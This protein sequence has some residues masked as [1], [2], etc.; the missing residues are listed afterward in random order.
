[1]K[2][3]AFYAEIRKSLFN[4]S[5]S[6]EQVTGIEGILNAFEDYG[7]DRDKTLAYALA[8][9]H[10]ETGRKMVPVREG[11]ARSDASARR[12]VARRKYGKPGAYG[13]VFYGRGHVQ[14]TW[15]SNY[16]HTGKKIGID[17]V[18]DPDRVLDPELSARVLIEGLLDGRWN[19]SEGEGI[20]HYLPTNGKDD[21]RGARR[22]VNI[23]DKW[24]L[25][26]SYYLKYLSAIQKA[27][28]VP[29]LNDEATDE[30][31]ADVEGIDAAAQP[32]AASGYPPRTWID[33][34]IDAI[35]ALFKG[36]KK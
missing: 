12:I 34:L 32:I 8:T 15:E 17:L 25:L 28:G 21:L 9:A 23:T 35:F 20:A 26:A 2:R 5:L 36:D 33:D 14:L 11:F 6:Q 4:G 10:H 27:G 30:P 13:H 7:D 1:M 22:T 18:K 16:C 24:E 31:P 3:A 19:G 29:Y